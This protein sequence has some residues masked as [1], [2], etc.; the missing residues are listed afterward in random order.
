[1][2][3]RSVCRY[4]SILY[5]CVWS[6]CLSVGVC[7]VCLSEG[8]CACKCSRSL[9]GQPCRCPWSWSH[10]CLGTTLQVPVPLSSLNHGAVPPTP[11]EVFMQKWQAM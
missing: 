2:R 8:V 3:E 11:E 4:V 6:L 7:E 9:W 5:V 1:M 10:R